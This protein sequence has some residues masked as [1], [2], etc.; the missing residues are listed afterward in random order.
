MPITP[1]LGGK[2]KR[3]KSSRLS[4]AIQFLKAN[5]RY[6]KPCVKKTNKSGAWWRTPLIP[7]LEPQK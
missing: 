7:A 4:L 1:A 2:G 5:L 3:V 6:M